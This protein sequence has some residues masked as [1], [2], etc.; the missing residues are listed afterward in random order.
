MK[1]NNIFGFFLLILIAVNN[2]YDANILFLLSN[3]SSKEV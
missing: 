3:F 1:N 2:Y